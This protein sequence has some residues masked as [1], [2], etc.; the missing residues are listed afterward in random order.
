M[1]ELQWPQ[2]LWST[3]TK[4]LNSQLR[5]CRTWN[6]T[7]RVRGRQV[8]TQ[9]RIPIES[10]GLCDPTNVSDH[11]V[12]VQG[13]NSKTVATATLVHR[14]VIPLQ[15]PKISEHIHRRLPLSIV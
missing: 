15:N 1:A 9:P 3:I 5:K 2:L 12:A 10:C 14:P 6:F 13:N 11:Q 4:S 8:K 7:Q